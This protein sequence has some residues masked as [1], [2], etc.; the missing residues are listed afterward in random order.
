MPG[1]WHHGDDIFAQLGTP[2]VAVADGTVTLV[3]WE[4]LGGWRLW[5]TD[6]AGDQFYYAH[7]SGY[8]PAVIGADDGGTVQVKAGEVLGFIGN[9]GDAFTTSPHLHFEVHR[10]GCS[11]SATT[12]PST[13]PA[14]SAPGHT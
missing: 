1:N 3:G 9:P 7:L 5:V 10:T 13:R 8:A 12:A 11:P 14:T 2:V 6:R 4:H